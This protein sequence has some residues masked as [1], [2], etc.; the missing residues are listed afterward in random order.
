[1]DALL[2]ELCGCDTEGMLRDYLPVHD[3]MIE[4]VNER[5][6]VCRDTHE[7]GGSPAVEEVLTC[8]GKIVVDGAPHRFVWSVLY[9]GEISLRSFL[10]VAS[11][12]EPTQASQQRWRGVA[13]QR[14]RRCNGS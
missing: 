13:F 14:L 6:M 5:V 11:P 7:Y 2:L 12:A 1:M 4:R 3:G 9:R 10:H 8:H